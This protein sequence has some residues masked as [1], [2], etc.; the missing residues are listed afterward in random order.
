MKNFLIITLIFLM[1]IQRP[2]II[3][4]QCTAT[5]KMGTDTEIPTINKKH[6]NSVKIEKM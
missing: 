2:M 3:I 6:R 4:L 1:K 5:F